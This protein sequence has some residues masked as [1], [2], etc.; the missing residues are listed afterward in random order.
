MWNDLPRCG[1]SRLGAA[2]RYRT[3]Q[4]TTIICT[5]IW[6][7]LGRFLPR[8]AG[9]QRGAGARR[10]G[11]R[12][13]RRG[14]MRRGRPPP[15][16]GTGTGRPPR[17]RPRPRPRLRL[18]PLPRPPPRP[19]AACPPS[20]PPLS[21]LYRAVGAPGAVEVEGGG[22][23]F[24]ALCGLVLLACFCLASSFIDACRKASGR[25]VK[26]SSSSVAVRV[27]VHR[28]ACVDASRERLP[29]KPADR[30][31]HTDSPSP[32][33]Q[34]GIQYGIQ[35]GIKSDTDLCGLLARRARVQHVRRV[36][37]P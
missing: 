34:Y 9:A 26:P 30:R 17:L 11:T 29:P 8:C 16:A 32:S 18:R 14:R 4:Y 20:A 10:R 22:L 12:R 37:V 3:P 1:G 33:A 13:F 27:R 36:Q 5:I 2:G 25:L 23:T 35:C 24:A 15:H 6:L 7:N 21:V 31:T 28:S 19:S